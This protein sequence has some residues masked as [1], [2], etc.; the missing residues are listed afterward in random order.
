MEL[1]LDQEG[2]RRFRH[3]LLDHFRLFFDGFVQGLLLP[4]TAIPDMIFRVSG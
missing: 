1:G 4:I 3:S 2:A